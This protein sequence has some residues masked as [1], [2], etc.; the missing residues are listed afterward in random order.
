MNSEELF[1]R[2]PGLKKPCTIGEI[3]FDHQKKRVDIFMDFPDTWDQEVH[4]PWDPQIG[5]RKTYLP[6]LTRLFIYPLPMFLLSGKE[7]FVGR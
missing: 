7:I 1:R 6:K 5:V 2:L 3:G 4:C